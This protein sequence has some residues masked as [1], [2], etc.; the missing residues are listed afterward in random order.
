MIPIIIPACKLEF[1]QQGQ[2]IERSLVLS[3]SCEK[4]Y[5]GLSVAVMLRGFGFQARDSFIAV[6]FFL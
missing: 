2:E 1:R 3:E 6:V 4:E 5:L